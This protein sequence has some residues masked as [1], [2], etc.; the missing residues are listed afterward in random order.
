M[1]LENSPFS[2]PYPGL[3]KTDLIVFGNTLE[4]IILATIPTSEKITLVSKENLASI[5]ET[6]STTRHTRELER[7]FHQRMG[8]K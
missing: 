2:T 6:L 8:K 3:R 7:A 4:E 1:F 5:K